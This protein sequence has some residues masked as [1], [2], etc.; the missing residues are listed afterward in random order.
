M[1]IK[2]EMMSDLL[3]KYDMSEEEIC[4]SLGINKQK[5]RRNLR[6]LSLIKQ[7]KNSDYGDQFKADMYTIF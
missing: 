7:Y 5:L 1:S 3:N 6:T 4:N 2:K